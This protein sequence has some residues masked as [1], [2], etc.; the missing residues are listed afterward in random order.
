MWKKKRYT[1]KEH[2]WVFSAWIKYINENFHTSK[3]DNRYKKLKQ[4]PVE[5]GKNVCCIIRLAD[6]PKAKAKRLQLK[7]HLTAEN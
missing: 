6:E 1:A 5:E 7:Q 3:K 4:I 2:N